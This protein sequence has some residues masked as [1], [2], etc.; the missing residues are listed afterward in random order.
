[1]PGVVNGPTREILC[2]AYHFPPVGG[3]GVQ[4]SVKFVRHL[5]GFGYQPIVVTGLGR[6]G[7]EWTPEDQSL[8]S[9]LPADLP[10]FRVNR[11]EPAGRSGLKARLDRW[12][13]LR[14]PWQRWWQEQCF[15]TALQ[16]AHGRR[17][18]LV[19]A[20]MAPY[21]TAAVAARVAGELGIPWVADLR[22]PWALDEM[23]VYPTGLH[24]RL[25]IAAMGQSLRSAAA[26]VMNTP[27]AAHALRREL[28]AVHPE[29]V[30][31]ITNG[32]DAEDFRGTPPPREDRAFRIA[33]TGFLHTWLGNRHQKGGRLRRWL[34]GARLEVDILTRSH[35][36]LLRALRALFAKDPLAR[37]EV[38]LHLAGPLTA[39]DRKVS[40]DSGLSDRIRTPGYLDHHRSVALL[41]TADLLFLPMHA[42]PA[43]ERS[44]IVPGKTYE[45]LAAGRPILAAVPAGDARD[46]LV[47][48][49][50]ARVCEPGDERA[51]TGILH[52]ELLR[53]RAERD[54]PAP[55]S[56]YL[57]RFERREL[58]RSLAG[59]FDLL[60]EPS[61]FHASSV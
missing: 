50:T 7:V 36:V 53:W 37:S 6:T 44:R 17:P 51:M 26:V 21:E 35:V 39:S 14:T 19:Y 30:F 43:G 15:T 57:R 5:P 2:L 22:D 48:A 45:Y 12:L 60:L 10:T 58:T 40:E 29:K 20:S 47:E 4:R 18:C 38:E 46:F 11:P 52:S 31:T 28:H 33:H 56:E 34:G 1:V 9:E 24:R 55:D 27:E 59:L 61:P 42:L 32:F 8:L 13:R 49:G 16:A 25:E 3:A 23:L 41:R 54:A